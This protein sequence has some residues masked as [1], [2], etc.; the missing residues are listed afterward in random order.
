MKN[1]V[2]MMACSATIAAAM[3]FQVLCPSVALAAKMTNDEPEIAVETSVETSESSDETSSVDVTEPSDT[4]S[5]YTYVVETEDLT[6]TEATEPSSD[7][8]E[9]ISSATDADPT[10]VTVDETVLTDETEETELTEETEEVEEIEYVVFDHYFTEINDT[11]VNTTELFVITSDSSVFTRNTNVVSNYDDAYIIECSSVEEARFVY[12]YY[13]DKVEFITD[14]SDVASI[15]TDDV[16]E[17]VPAEESVV[18]ETEPVE[19]TEETTETVVETDA[20][21][22]NETSETTVDTTESTEPVEQEPDIADLSDLNNGNDAI[23]NLNDIDT[24]HNDYS[25]YI[26]LIDTGAN[27]HANFTVLDGDTFDHNGHGTEM[28]GYIR[29]E[30]PQAQ[31]V[32]IKV[33]EDG[34]ASAADIY[35]GFRLAIDLNVSVINFSM[36]APDIAKNAVIRDII[37]EALDAGIVVI[38]AAGNNSISATHFIPGCIDGVITVGA[39]NEIGKKISSSNYNADYYVVAN[40]TSEATARYTGL[41]TAG[42]ADISGKVFDQVEEDD[43]YI[44]DDYAWATEVA[45]MLTDDLVARYGYGYVIPEIHEDGTVSYRYVMETDDFSVAGWDV[46]T[47]GT[48]RFTSAVPYTV[49][50]GS[51]SGTCDYHSDAGGRGY[52]SNISGTFGAYLAAAGRTTA[53]AICSKNFGETDSDGALSLPSGTGYFYEATY[54]NGE[55]HYQIGHSTNGNVDQPDWE[56]RSYD[57]T[58]S[59]NSD[60]R[61]TVTDPY[62]GTSIGNVEIRT[63]TAAEVI[64]KINSLVNDMVAVGEY[65]GNKNPNFDSATSG[66]GTRTLHAEYDHTDDYQ[67]YE[68]QTIEPTTLTS[69]SI[70]IRKVDGNGQALSGATFSFV[71]VGGVSTETL[72]SGTATPNGTVSG[73]FSFITNGSTAVIDGLQ[74]NSSYTIYETD[75]PSGYVVASPNFVQFTTD[76]NGNPIA[77]SSGPWVWNSGSYTYTLANGRSGSL[78]FNKVKES[79]SGDVAGAGIFF[80]AATTNTAPNPFSGMT[81]S[82]GAT[83]YSAGTSITMPDGSTLNAPSD[84]YYFVTNGSGA[85]FTASNLTSGA[86]YIFTEIYV[87]SGYGKAQDIIVTVDAQGNISPN[88]G[89]IT[90]LEPGTT[91]HGSL[92]IVKTFDSTDQ[93]GF[94]GSIYTRGD[95]NWGWP[96]IETGANGCTF[97][98]YWYGADASQASG[99]Y[100]GVYSYGAGAIAEGRLGAIRNNQTRVMWAPGA[101]YNSYIE[102]ATT[103]ALPFRWIAGNGEATW[104]LADYSTNTLGYLVSGYYLVTE[105]WQTGVFG[106][107]HGDTTAEALYVSS[108]NAGGWHCVYNTGLSQKWDMMYHVTPQGTYRC[109]IGSGT[110]GITDVASLEHREGDNY[111]EL[112]DGRDMRYAQPSYVD[113]T[114]CRNVN[115]GTSFDITKIDESGLG[116][117]GVS[118]ALWH[119][120]Q[121][122]ALGIITNPNSP[123]TTTDGADQYD[124]GWVYQL[125][126]PQGVYVGEY[127]FRME[128]QNFCEVYAPDRATAEWVVR[129]NSYRDNGAGAWGNAPSNYAINA[130]YT[131]PNLQIYWQPD[132][133][134]HDAYIQN[135]ADCAAYYGE[136][137]SNGGLGYNSHYAGSAN[138]IANLPLGDYQV[139]EYYDPSI[140]VFKTPDGWSGP[141]TDSTGTYFYKNI[142]IDDLYDGI[143][144]N[145][146][147]V[148]ETLGRIDLTKINVTGGPITDFT[149]S[150]TN[151]TSGENVAYGYIPANATPLTTNTHTETDYTY[152]ASWDFDVNGRRLQGRNEAV[153]GLGTFLIREYIPATAVDDVNDLVPCDGWDGPVLE[154]SSYVYSRTVVI[155]DTNGEDLQTVTLRNRTNIIIG[156]TLT[157]FANRHITVVGE[158]IEFTDVVAYD[159]CYI[160]ATYTMHATLVGT[161]GQPIRDRNGNTYEGTTVFTTTSGS[162]TVPVT[163]TVNTADLVEATP[164]PDGTLTYSPRSVVCF[165]DMTLENGLVL[166]QEADANN[167][168]QTVTVPN[169]E[170]GTEFADLQTEEHETVSGRIV[171]VVDHC[172]FSGL[173]IGE[174]YTLTCRLY[175]QTT[176]NALQYSNGDLVIGTKTFVPTTESGTVDVTFTIDTSDLL[177]NVFQYEERTLVAF[178]YL[179]TENGILIGGHTDIDDLPQHVTPRLPSPR[180]S[181]TDD[182]TGSRVGR[183]GAAVPFTDRVSYTN[184]NIGETYQMRSSVVNR[185]D[186]SIVYATATVNF[187]PTSRDGY[188]DVHFTIDTSAIC[189][190]SNEAYIVCFEQLWQLDTQNTGRGD[191]LLARHEDIRDQD[192]TIYLPPEVHT[193]MTDVVTNSNYGMIGEN[194]EFVDV[195]SYYRLHIGET[196]EVTGTLMDKQTGLPVLDENGQPITASTTFQPQTTDGTVEVTY[197][198]NT[199]RLIQQVGQ[200][201]NGVTIEAPREIVSFESI[202]SSSGF[203]FEIHADINDEGQTIILGDISSGAGDVQTS[204]SWLAAGMTT[205]RDTVHYRGLGPVEYTVR[206]SLHLVDYDANGNPI[207]GGLI[208]ARAGEVTETSYTW[209][210]STH[211]G[212]VNLDY[213]IDST[214]FAGRNIIVFEELWYNGTCIIS[215]EHYCDANGGYG[216][217]NLEQ[218]VRVASLHTN[219]YSFQTGAQMVARDTQATINDFCYYGNVEIGQNYFVE[220]TLWGCYTDENGNIHSSPISKEDGGQVTSAVFTATQA[221]GVVEVQFTINSLMLEQ[222]GYDYVV[223]TERLIHVGSNVCIANHSDLSDQ[224]QTIMIPDVRTTAS[225]DT[226]RTL[227]EGN[228]PDIHRVTVRDRVY[229]ENLVC[230][231]SSSYTVVGNLQYAKTDANGNITESGALIQNGQPV[232][233][234]VTFVP[235]SPT[236]YIDIEFTVD[237]SDIMAREIDKIVVFEDLYYGPE[238]IIVAQHAD[239]SDQEQT[240]ETPELHTT[241]LGVNGRHS[242]QASANTEIVDRIAYSGLTP[243][244]TYRMETDL[245]SSKTGES[246]A[247]VTTLFTPTESSGI[248]EVS[249]TADLSGYT[250]GDYVVVFE[251]CYDNETNILIKSHHNWEDT[252]QTVTT[253]GWDTGVLDVNANKYLYCAIG[254]VVVL[255][256][257]VATEGIKKRRLG[258]QSN[259]NTES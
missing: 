155:D 114:S 45:Q 204:T 94:L 10:D 246:I 152:S 195:V 194:V 164:N 108:M 35:A 124:V 92:A 64:A 186:P 58:Y 167:S 218:T 21:E 106:V 146:T 65:A 109:Q 177:V 7:E 63:A 200:T 97:S 18:E 217:N 53:P 241:A 78:S 180:T 209:T 95:L 142:T 158:N 5:D 259:N 239:I 110:S 196:Y 73:G 160:G 230:D 144:Y 83:W 134:I 113:Y 147:A 16:D 118:F 240:V 175:D 77:S 54:A 145:V 26:A 90:M 127:P 104:E 23:A 40:S 71:R 243:S 107:F 89:A 68:G 129:N 121:A 166:V 238:G 149:F 115:A 247:H 138:E 184:L 255:L 105:Q 52:I 125:N 116:V 165:E 156:T 101:E 208:P 66:T 148:N 11:Q 252:D 202:R 191:V 187:E 258:G 37:Q 39:V 44:P 216:M 188:V 8:T 112:Q 215:H 61:V 57:I 137:G 256:G 159:G 219:A 72:V 133:W 82:A 232:T 27:A 87:P 74:P 62:Y 221:S 49:T 248:L 24:V 210:P 150:I 228:M 183:L 199:L 34:T 169:P 253:G 30:N 85:D 100:N 6:E 22:A 36:T 130:S 76:G 193:Q 231:G 70:S 119:G 212:N 242:V 225:T 19:V 1:R 244:R 190:G 43:D 91:P 182:Q 56:H 220:G 181:F 229:Y 222:R 2:H 141:V 29:S 131:I 224:A 245:M 173:H 189:A 226:G 51:Y 50:P 205:V 132:E 102:N 88:S 254:C 84:G 98:C 213:R 117:E 227:A 192:Q 14:M 15:A 55:W 233:N 157:D 198:L 9:V 206:G 250:A 179:R 171:E 81:V 60:G 3:M 48:Y 168:D 139:R 162:G 17:D 172:S 67:V 176:G 13:I 126:Y 123:N 153:V 207:D 12:S 154:G 214:R 136:N 122:I 80:A 46:E 257:L 234:T 25:G 69:G 151:V 251:D 201:I 235:T 4:S 79:G 170:I 140:S 120:D 185:D 174:T 223:V 103:A 178:E 203:D 38:G 93:F 42:E 86:T 96:V 75:A 135:N 143:A 31:V 99:M 197:H 249:I 163:F 211:E 236:G 237:V 161:N 47:Y 28:F 33:S 59:V 111:N 32:S 128:T 41:Y 20:T